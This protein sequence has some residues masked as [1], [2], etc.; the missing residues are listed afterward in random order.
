MREKLA[1]IVVAATMVLVVVLAIVAAWTRS[2]ASSDAPSVPV[3]PAAEHTPADPV[4]GEPSA[5]T[6][7]DRGRAVYEAQRCRMCHSLGGDGNV[8]SPLDGVGMRLSDDEIRRWIVAPQEMRPGV[9][10]GGYR[11]SDDDLDALVA[12]LKSAGARGRSSRPGP[13]SE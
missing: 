2:T 7:V 12:F 8:R 11:L 5:P 4:A 13:P 10:K 6:L 3:M 9:A 1:K